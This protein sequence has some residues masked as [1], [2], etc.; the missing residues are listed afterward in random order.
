MATSGIEFHFAARSDIGLKR[1]SNQDSA[2]AGANLLVLA[3]GM[4]GAAGG[5]IA[6]SVAIAH[7]APLD[8]ESHK[9]EELLPLLHHAFQDAHDELLARAAEN[10]EIA[11]LGTTCIALLRAGNKLAMAHIGDSRAYLLRNGSLTQVTTD[12]SFVQFLISQGEI[13][14][15]EAQEHPQRN[16]VTKVLGY[17]EISVEPDE[18]IREAVIADRWLLCSDGLHGLVSD[19]TIE[20]IL[21]DVADPAE[22]AESL[23]SLALRAGGTDNVTCVVADIVPA[24]HAGVS[25]PQVVGAAS[26]ERFSPSR[27]GESAAAKAAQLTQTGEQ[28]AP[29]ASLPEPQGLTPQRHPWR[30]S[31]LTVLL[32][33]LL[34]GGGWLGYAWSQTQYYVTG[35]SGN[36]VI[37]RGIPQSIGSW[38]LSSPIEVTSLRMKDLPQAEQ[39]RLVDPVIRS[40]RAEIDDYLKKLH[41][42]AAKYA[43]Q[44]QADAPQSAKSSPVQSPQSGTGSS[45]S[46]QSGGR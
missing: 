40:S 34:I 30:V 25:T 21:A 43:Q 24:G 31:L 2:Y 13:T 36:I 12:H 15:E 32:T 38:Q 23:I 35:A 6:S 7:L 9:A 16:A 3:D 5:D 10:P 19:S 20:E 14:P 41:A 46:P 17:E 4:G 45:A 22:C 11:G 28:E 26:Q 1:T 29:V 39:Q 37:Y 18:T 27:L 42:S 8:F 44:K 33:A